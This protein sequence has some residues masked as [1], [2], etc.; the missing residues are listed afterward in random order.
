MNNKLLSTAF[1]L[2]WICDILNMPFME[3][4]DTTYPL[5]AAFYWLVFIFLGM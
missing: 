1:T 4:F 5:N 2:F 3:Q